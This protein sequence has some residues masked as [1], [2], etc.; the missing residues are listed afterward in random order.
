MIIAIIAIATAVA[1]IVLALLAA[2][3]AS[4]AAYSG[5][6]NVD[7]FCLGGV[8]TPFQFLILGKPLNR[9]SLVCGA[10]SGGKGMYADG[11]FPH[12]FK[13]CELLAIIVHDSKLPIA[14]CASA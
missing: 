6:R 10:E 7:L 3:A 2:R 13:A 14:Y 9:K 4:Q 1:A 5:A 8:S 11:L 12:L